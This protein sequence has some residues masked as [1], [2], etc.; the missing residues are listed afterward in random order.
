MNKREEGL[1]EIYNRIKAARVELGIVQFRRSPTTTL[2]KVPMCIMLEDVD[3]IIKRPS[4]G[5]VAYP[6]LRNVDIILELA[7]N[8]DVTDI[9][10]LVLDLRRV[11]FAGGITVAEKTIIE[12]LRLEGP[13]G[14]GVPDILGMRLILG[15]VYTDEGILS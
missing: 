1:V 8:E 12:E 6:V 15:M 10:S 3:E 14:Y 5:Q 13:F 11:V 7:V 4:R 2:D 9:R